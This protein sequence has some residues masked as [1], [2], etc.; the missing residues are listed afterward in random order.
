MQV[1]KNFII[2]KFYSFI[3]TVLYIFYIVHY[4]IKHYIIYLSYKIYMYIYNI[5]IHKTRE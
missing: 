3:R 5:Y 1:L 4:T 2:K